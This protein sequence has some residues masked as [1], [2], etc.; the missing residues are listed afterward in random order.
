MPADPGL[1]PQDRSIYLESN[2]IVF[3]Q[4]IEL[5]TG[6]D[7]G[8]VEFSLLVHAMLGWWRGGMSRIGTP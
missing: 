7:Q 1:T 5:N 6:Q 8:V 4:Q 3:G 2:S